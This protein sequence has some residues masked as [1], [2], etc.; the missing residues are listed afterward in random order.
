M[1]DQM[2]AGMAEATRLTREGR[3][4]E[5]TALIRRTFGGVFVPAADTA[6][7]PNEPIGAPSRVENEAPQPTA[8][9]PTGPALRRAPKPSGK[10]SRRFRGMLRLPGTA[11]GAIPDF[12]PSPVVPTGGR[13]V[14]RS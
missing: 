10:A 12:C 8:P 1:N 5:A 6:D 11:P 9:D 7:G 2:Q 4:G 3:L 13:I 14:E